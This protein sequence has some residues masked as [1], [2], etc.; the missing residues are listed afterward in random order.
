MMNL[1]KSFLKEE[2]GMGTIEIVVIIAVLVMVAL[3]FRN[4][5]KEFVN[6][7]ME[8]FFNT[9]NIQVTNPGETN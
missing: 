7:L 3:V 1:F 9:D 2:D 5:I 6:N 4:G 8:K